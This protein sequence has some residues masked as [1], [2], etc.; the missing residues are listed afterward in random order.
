MSPLSLQPN[1]PPAGDV[2]AEP[3]RTMLWLDIIDTRGELLGP[4]MELEMTVAREAIRLP[5][6][7]TAPRC[8]PLC[9]SG[10]VKLRIVVAAA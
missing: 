8:T 2:T 4:S 5:L 7:S 6:P 3:P 9:L 10:E 1:T